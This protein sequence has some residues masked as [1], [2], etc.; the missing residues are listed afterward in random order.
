MQ[1][2]E[3]IIRRAIVHIMDGE[4]GYPVCSEEELELSPDL[5]DFFRGLIYKLL[6]GDDLKK[7][8]FSEEEPSEV[9]EIVKTFEEDKLIEAS[10]ELAQDLYTIMNA[11][12]AIPSGDFAVVS[13]QACSVM[14][15]ALLKMNYKESFVHMT[16]AG[17]NGNVN[18]IVCYQSTLPAAGAKLSE[19]VVINLSDYSVQI[20]EKKYDINGTK[21]NYLSEMYLKCKAGMSSKTKLAIVTRAVEQVNQKHFSEEPV[22]Q[23][24]A[25]SILKKEI[26]ESGSINVE[27]ISEKI[28]GSAPEIKEEFDAKMEKYHMEKAEVAPQSEA[29]TKKFEKQYLKT[30]TGIEINIP[31]EQYQDASQVEFL[32]NPDGTISV[33]I[34]NINKISTR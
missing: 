2:D 34:K 11:N 27:K 26:E 3:I 22:R 21:V 6:S 25:K 5:N 1:Q 12:L 8:Y 10:K 15:L 16:Q 13:F 33:L 30:D 17:E 19:A 24:E 31:M 29:T 23:M 18:Q 28:Y 9:Y 7:C 14:Y 20:V 32:T 4:L